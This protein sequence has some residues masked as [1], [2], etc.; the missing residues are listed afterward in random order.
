MQEVIVEGW[1]SSAP[2]AGWTPVSGTQLHAPHLRLPAAWWVY[3]QDLCC[4]YVMTLKL[5]SHLTM[6]LNWRDLGGIMVVEELLACWAKEGKVV[7]NS[8]YC[9][10]F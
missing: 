4:R 2:C 9:D 3:P 6:F 8:G 5:A 7:L 10:W 1:Q